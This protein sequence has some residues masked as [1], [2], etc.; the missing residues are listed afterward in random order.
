M[1]CKLSQTREQDR[2]IGDLLVQGNRA[3]RKGLRWGPWNVGWGTG[4]GKGKRAKRQKCN[5][6]KGQKWGAGMVL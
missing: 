3:N 6:E 2:E 5:K 4:M 1:G